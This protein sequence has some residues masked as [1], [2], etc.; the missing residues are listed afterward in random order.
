MPASNV[1]AFL[2][3]RLPI[4]WGSFSGA[5]E[6]PWFVYL[7]ECNNGRLYAGI[8]TDPEARF[9]RYRGPLWGGLLRKEGSTCGYIATSLAPHVRKGIVQR[10]VWAC[11][12][13]W[14]KTTVI[15][16]SFR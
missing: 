13:G 7:L 10:T 16:V 2:Y 14:R 6:K 9:K 4:F 1:S 5:E 12:D 15:I 11:P 8:T 3:C